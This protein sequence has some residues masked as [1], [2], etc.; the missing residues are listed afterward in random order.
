MCQF[1]SFVSNGQGKFFYLNSRQRKEVRES[2]E[3]PDSHS[4]IIEY[5]Q[6]KGELAIGNSVEDKFNKY[7]FV[8][9]ERGFKFIVDQINTKDDSEEAEK[10][11][12]NLFENIKLEDYLDSYNAYFYCRYIKDR[13]EIRKLIT[14][15]YYAYYY[16]LNVK[17]RPEIRKNITDSCYAYHY[18]LNVKDRPEIRK[19]IT[20]SINAYCYCLDVK[21]RP[22]I[23]K[24]ITDSYDAYY[25][26]LNVKDRPEIRELITD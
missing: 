3:N 1:F 21:D 26:C 7:E 15:S 20:D 22:E 16:C 25:Y 10:F 9:N 19:N 12:E 23:R 13:P 11:V 4:F 14:D 2:G 6:K 8:F 5:F 17:D 24:N 18:C